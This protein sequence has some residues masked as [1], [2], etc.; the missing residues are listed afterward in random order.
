VASHQTTVCVDWPVM[1][2]VSSWRAVYEVKMWWKIANSELGCQPPFTASAT[3][4]QWIDD[5]LWCV[6]DCQVL[7]MATVLCPWFDAECRPSWRRQEQLYRYAHERTRRSTTFF[8][9]R[10]VTTGRSICKAK[11]AQWWSCGGQCQHYC[12]KTSQVITSSRRQATT[13]THCWANLARKWRSSY[14][15]LTRLTTARRWRLVGAKLPIIQ[16]LVLLFQRNNEWMNRPMVDQGGWVPLVYVAAFDW[17]SLPS[18]LPASGRHS[19]DR[20][21]GETCELNC[22]VAATDGVVVQSFKAMTSLRVVIRSWC[23]TPRPRPSA[24]RLPDDSLRSRTLVVVFGRYTDLLSADMGC[25]LYIGLDFYIV[26]K[27]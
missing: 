26:T 18:L 4:V 14:W 7:S 11:A 21:G 8:I 9:K 25:V 1:G 10:E 19:H 12:N 5:T 16:I 23:S 24:R 3:D 20:R 22:T 13:L 17:P 15:R 2:W 27:I 6:A